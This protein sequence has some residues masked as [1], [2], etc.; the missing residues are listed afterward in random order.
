MQLPHYF[1]G[2]VKTSSIATFG[3]LIAAKANVHI[4]IHL[5][6]IL[7]ATLLAV[8]SWNS[9]YR[10]PSSKILLLAIAFA[11]LDL[12]QIMETLESLGVM[13]V[14]L[15]LPLLGIEFIHTVSFA[16]VALLAAGVLKKEA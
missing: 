7:L 3:W 4:A 6:G 9:Y 16:T 11:L 2:L 8:V 1:G 10:N 12:S 15:S 14:N 13:F 5:V